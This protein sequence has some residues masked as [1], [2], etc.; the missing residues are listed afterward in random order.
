MSLKK[1]LGEEWYEVLKDEFVKDY[2]I[3]LSL[4]IKDRQ[5]KTTVYPKNDDIFNA[6]KFTPYNK[7][8]VCIIGQ[9][10][11]INENQAHGLSFSVENGKST[12]SLRQIA[13]AV[14]SDN[15]SNNLTRW[16][17]QGVMLLNN[18]LTV[19]AGN[20]NSHKNKGWEQFTQKTVELLDRQNILF[21]LW[22]KD[23]QTV[24]PFIK[25]SIFIAC[26]HPVASVYQGREWNN[27]DC[28]N[29]INKF[30]DHRIIW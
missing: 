10:P 20:S 23:A 22:G 30:Y 16:T 2:M 5:S 3:N 26:E 6:Y 29:S 9:D 13:K 4:F 25:E 18:V 21:L 27:K 8:K 11:Y 14:N 7:V 28:F 19:D 17:E 12:P 24:I 15:W 1:R